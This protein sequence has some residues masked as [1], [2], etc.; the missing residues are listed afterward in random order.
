MS[1]YVTMFIHVSSIMF[2]V[3][4][5]CFL[6]EASKRDKAAARPPRPSQASDS[7]DILSFSSLIYEDVKFNEQL[8]SHDINPATGL[9]M[10][11][12]G[13]DAGGNMYGFDD[14]SHHLIV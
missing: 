8:D 6:P 13:L 11:D 9:P 2:I 10:L 14:S 12:S 5:V 1:Y 4:G 3:F 7:R